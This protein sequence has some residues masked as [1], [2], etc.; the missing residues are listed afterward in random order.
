MGGSRAP[1]NTIVFPGSKDDW[2]VGRCLLLAA[3]SQRRLSR[4]RHL[5]KGRTWVGTEEVD[6]N[7]EYLPLH[8]NNLPL[9]FNNLPLHF[10]N[11]PLNLNEYPL[12]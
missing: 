1:T 9:H 10:N 8:F 7:L 2:S 4:K 12:I 5:T 6:N 11:L 3:F